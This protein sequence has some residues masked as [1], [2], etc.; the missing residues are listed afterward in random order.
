MIENTPDYLKA[1]E[2]RTFGVALLES[3][4]LNKRSGLAV[5]TKVQQAGLLSQVPDSQ[6]I[7]FACL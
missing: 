1:S 5:W 7:Y 6:T 3:F 2:S 4:V